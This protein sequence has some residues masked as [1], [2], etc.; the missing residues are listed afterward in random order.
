M[1]GDLLLLLVLLPVS[2]ILNALAHELGHAIAGKL[3]G[4]TIHRIAIVTDLRKAPVKP[5]FTVGDTEFYLAANS[6][7]SFITTSGVAFSQHPLKAIFF[8]LAGPLSGA[9]VGALFAVYAVGFTATTF[10]NVIA[11]CVAVFY[12]IMDLANLKPELQAY[13]TPSDGWKVREA[14]RRFRAKKRV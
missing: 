3:V 5:L 6:L 2:F 10:V 1:L 14:W 13:D 7:V 4:L 9:L 11:V 12:V 8:N